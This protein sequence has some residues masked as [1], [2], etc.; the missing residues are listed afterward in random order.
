MDGPG[1]LLPTPLERTLFFCLRRDGYVQTSG[2]PPRTSGR[3]DVGTSGRPVVA[4]SQKVEEKKGVRGG[5]SEVPL[6]LLY[7]KIDFLN[8]NHKNL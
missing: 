6:G 2:G 3:L 1:G 7:K 8:F 5:G 4:V